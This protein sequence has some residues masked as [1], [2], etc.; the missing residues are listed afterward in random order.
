[1]NI[2]PYIAILMPF[3]PVLNVC[4]HHSF[5]NTRG[6]LRKCRRAAWYHCANEESDC[7]S[8]WHTNWQSAIWQARQQCPKLVCFTE[9]GVDRKLDSKNKETTECIQKNK[10]K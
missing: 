2:L 1:M 9:G 7:K 5:E 8:I 6:S 4:T 3:M 10:K